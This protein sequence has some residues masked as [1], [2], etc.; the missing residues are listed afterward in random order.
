[1]A[2]VLLPRT[3]RAAVWGGRGPV[4]RPRGVGWRS[5][6]AGVKKLYKNRHSC[7]DPM[8]YHDNKDELSILDSEVN[9]DQHEIDR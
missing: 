1:M 5:G 2:P 3:P 6:A 8:R 4:A 7:E 9:I